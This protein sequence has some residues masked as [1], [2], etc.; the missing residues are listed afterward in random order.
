MKIIKCSF[1]FSILYLLTLWPDIHKFE[2]IHNIF[3]PAH[4]ENY[5]TL[6]ATEKTQGIDISEYQGKVDF[7]ILE[8]TSV[9]FVYIKATQGADYVDPTYIIH[10]NALSDSK[11]LSGAYHFYD[12]NDDPVTQAHHFVSQV[13]SSKHFLPPML[14]VEQTGKLSPSE[15]KVGIKQW[16]D[17]VEKALDCRP[18]IY[19]YGD[20]WLENIGPSFNTYDFWLADYA[21]KAQP[22][23]GL[24]NWRVW[25]YS[26]EGRLPGVQN[27]VDLDV[28]VAGELSCNTE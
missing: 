25:Q 12:P 9:R 16:L 17:Y 26:S 15:I 4:A 24:S 18:I 14:D 3:L 1:I 8:K 10:R 28:V 7:K 19:S 23:E 13:K 27:S 2:I 22:P 6:S 11:L 5:F 20:F 21:E